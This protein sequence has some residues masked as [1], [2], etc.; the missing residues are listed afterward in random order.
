MNEAL[1][2]LR[3]TLTD[4]AVEGAEAPEADVP[5]AA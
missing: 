5:E 4:D 2:G 1:D 3:V